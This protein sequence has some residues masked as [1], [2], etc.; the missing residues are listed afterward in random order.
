MDSFDRNK[1]PFTRKSTNRKLGKRKYSTVNSFSS[2]STSST[3]FQSFDISCSEKF[4]VFN[5]EMDFNFDQSPLISSNS[6]SGLKETIYDNNKDTNQKKFDLLTDYYKQIAPFKNYSKFNL[7]C[8]IFQ[9]EIN[10]SNERN[11]YLLNSHL[12]LNMH[13]RSLLLQWIIEVCS[14]YGFKRDTYY[15]T[16]NLIDRFLTS[17][18]NLQT[19]RFQLLGVAALMLAAKYEEVYLPRVDDFRLMTAGAYSNIEIVT[20]EIT[21]LQVFYLFLII[22]I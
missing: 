20:F 22:K 6:S 17:T 13:M 4:S 5:D 9:D 8:N 10:Y 15:L 19:S 2:L 11:I 3:K 12:E 18:C 21:M 1:S 7:Q 16:V 14:Q